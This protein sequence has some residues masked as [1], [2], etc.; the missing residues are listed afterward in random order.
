M[1]VIQLSTD[2]VF[3]GSNTR[4]Y[5]EDDPTGPLGVY[6]RS[7]LAGERAVAAATAN[8]AILRTAWVYAPFGQNFV[9]SMLRLAATRDSL[10]VVADQRGCPT[11]ALDI[12][13]AVLAVA[14][15]LADGDDPAGRG[16]FHM[17]G[18]GETT[19]ADFATAIL[20]VSRQYGGPHAV[21]TPIATADYPTPA[22]R[23]RNSRL[24]RLQARPPAWR[25][26]AR[27]ANLPAHVRGQAPRGLPSMKGIILAGGSGTPVAPHDPHG[28][29]A[30]CFPSTTSR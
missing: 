27:V 18:A 2:Y 29:E 28:L 30:N 24:R 10:N 1:P 26:P 19:W 22:R 17:A 15:H 13:D 12:A 14:R 6:G 4:P 20:D 5:R 23:P 25:D 3:D 8:H 7:K 21:V 9:R 11:S 16:T